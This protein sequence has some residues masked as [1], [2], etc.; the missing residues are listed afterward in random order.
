M[1]LGTS[2]LLS[3]ACGTYAIFMPMHYLGVAAER[4]GTRQYTEV[5]YL[6]KL[7][8]IHAFMTYAAIITI[9]AQF[10]LSSIFSGACSK[11]RSEQTIRGRLRRWN[12]RLQRLRHT[13]ILAE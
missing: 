13:I 6:Q 9:A 4:G 8:P 2:A 3:D 12:G 10:I 5:A 11:G 7:M 1:N